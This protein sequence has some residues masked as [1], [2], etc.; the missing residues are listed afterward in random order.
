MPDPNDKPTG[1]ADETEEPKGAADA[2]QQTDAS[3]KGDAGDASLMY[4]VCSKCHKFLEV[5]PG[6][7]EAM[8]HTYCDE[9]Y[10]EMMTEIEQV[11]KSK[12]K[13]KRE[14]QD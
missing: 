1:A 4:V 5:R 10:A 3:E 13:K 9:C 2:E 14:E 7:I 6:P 12:K 8:T 11:L